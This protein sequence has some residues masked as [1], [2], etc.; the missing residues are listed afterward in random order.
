MESWN[1]VKNT[2]K[3]AFA[4]LG[5]LTRQSQKITELMAE[6]S[7]LRARLAENNKIIASLKKALDNNGEIVSEN[8]AYWRKDG[9]GN[10]VE[11]PFCVSCFICFSP[12]GASCKKT[13]RASWR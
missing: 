13:E 3:G 2:V 9:L 1:A 8:C 4:N 11:G 6:R 10:I 5:N 12:V 7:Q